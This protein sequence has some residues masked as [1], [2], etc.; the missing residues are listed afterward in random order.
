MKKVL[1]LVFPILLLASCKIY[2]TR[3]FLYN[4]PGI[5]DNKIMPVRIVKAGKPQPLITSPGYMD[6]HAPD[7]LM[8]L[9]KRTHTVAFL[10]MRNDSILY[11]WYARGYSDSS[12]TNPFSATKSIVSILTGIALKDGKIKSLDEPVCDYYPP[13]R[14]KGLDKITFKNLLCMSSGVNFRD[15]YLNPAGPTSQIYYGDNMRG[16]IDSFYAER[17]A[18]TFFR[19]KN[20]DPEI[21]TL[22]LQNAVGMNMSDYASQKLWKPIGADHDAQWIVD[23]PD[24]A[25]VEKSYCCFHTDARDIARIG[26]L[27]EHKGNWRGYQLVDSAYV[28]ASLTPHRLP[29]EQGKPTNNYG[30]FWWIRGGNANKNFSADGLKGQ[31]VGVM[32]EQHLI[33][34]RL[35]KRDWLKPG[36]RFKEPKKLYPIL[37][38][39]VQAIWGK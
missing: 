26:I 20:C 25:G 17:P 19:Y 30:Y 3:A 15:S 37:S 24:S 8:H 14:K 34:V 33:F 35:G 31:Y 4:D 29:T 9:L 6:F 7:S 28:D 32:P 27:Y 21:L 11:E 38:A 16:L 12:L 1:F 5:Q 23:K 22:A 2:V 39:E 18:G 36:Q 13:Y 10:V